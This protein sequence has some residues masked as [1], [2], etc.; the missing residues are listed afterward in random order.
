MSK[1][2][3]VTVSVSARATLALGTAT[4]SFADA[5]P[6]TTPIMT[7][8]SFTVDVKG[9]TSGGST[10]TL[11]VL[12]DHDLTNAANETIG[13]DNLKWTVG[14]NPGF[15]AGTMSASTAQSV[16]SWNNS[17]SHSDNV[18]LTMANSWSY[19]VGS[20]TATLTYTLTAP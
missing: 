19:N 9:R 11:T 1:T 7:A 14:G 18:T 6:D 15:A 2:V 16:G 4:V 10:V 13:I 3:A 17:G 12:A 20:Y 8:P 5:D